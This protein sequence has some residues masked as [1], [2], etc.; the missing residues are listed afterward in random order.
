MLPWLEKKKSVTVYK[1]TK[2][3][4][5]DMEM[6]SEVEAPDSEMDEGLKEAAEDILRAINSKS[7]MDL[8]KAIKS[9]FEIC[10]SYPHEEGEHI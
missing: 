10:D 5:P 9:A 1:S 7:A 4:S 3:K 6:N 2:G 8:A